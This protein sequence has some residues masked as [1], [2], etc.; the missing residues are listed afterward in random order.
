MLLELDALTEIRQRMG[1]KIKGERDRTRERERDL[2]Q[3][4]E[5]GNIDHLYEKCDLMM[6]IMMSQ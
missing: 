1:I 5:R 3:R 4:G 2:K 6:L